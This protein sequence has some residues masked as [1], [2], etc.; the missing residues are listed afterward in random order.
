MTAELVRLWASDTAA[1]GL[2]DATEQ[3]TD[4]PAMQSSAA[5]LLDVELRVERMREVATKLYGRWLRGARD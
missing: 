5:L 2:V 3:R 1:G 4:A